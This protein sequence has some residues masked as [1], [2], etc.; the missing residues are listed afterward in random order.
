[1]LCGRQRLDSLET[2]HHSA[3]T[4]LWR[5]AM[6]FALAEDLLGRDFERLAEPEDLIERRSAFSYLDLGKGGLVRADG[7]CE[8]DLTQ[9]AFKARGADAGSDRLSGKQRAL[10][11]NFGHS[12]LLGAEYQAGFFVKRLSHLDQRA[13]RNIT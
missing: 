4:K 1:M 13:E 10:L 9:A 2:A 12:H 5:G 7:F 6:V 11:M 3:L 8:L